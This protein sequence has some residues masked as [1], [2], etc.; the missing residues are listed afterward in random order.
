MKN[1]WSYNYY[2]KNK[3]KSKYILLL[4]PKENSKEDSKINTEDEKHIKKDK[5]IIHKNSSIDKKR[6]ERKRK[7][8]KFKMLRNFSQKFKSE[9][10]CLEDP[11][12]STFAKRLLSEI[13]PTRIAKENKKMIFKGRRKFSET[14]KDLG[15]V[16]ILSPK[17]IIEN[18]KNNKNKKNKKL[19]HHNNINKSNNLSKRHSQSIKPHERRF[20][21]PRRMLSVQMIP[22]TNLQSNSKNFLFEHKYRGSY[23]Q[24]DIEEDLDKDSSSIET[25]P[26]ILSRNDTNNF[27]R[28]PSFKLK[29][30]NVPFEQPKKMTIKNAKKKT[31]EKERESLVK[32][33]KKSLVLN[34]S[35]PEIF[36]L[37]SKNS[38][39]NLSQGKK[40]NYKNKINKIP[41]PLPEQK[42]YLKKCDNKKHFCHEKFV[43]KFLTPINQF[44]NRSFKIT[45][46][47]YEKINKNIH[48]LNYLINNNDYTV[49]IHKKKKEKY[50][51]FSPPKIPNINRI[52]ETKYN[53]LFNEIKYYKYKI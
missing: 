47:E 50:H 9:L 42:L 46:M 21:F 35:N 16:R 20:C 41:K 29:L 8:P 7:L 30:R 48:D 31:E 49:F 38:Q 36:F 37:S 11:S 32:K 53:N 23:I 34:N 2:L 52:V 4:E 10:L 17:K 28:K 45:D 26:F 27:Q 51:E 25:S 22:V 40:N 19:Y 44:M 18:F 39:N 3:N 14:D 13:L 43:S 6:K 1:S 24:E 33:Y 5:K 12:K 15:L